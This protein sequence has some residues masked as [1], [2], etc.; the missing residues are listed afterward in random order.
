MQK[1]DWTDAAIADLERHCKAGAS[2]SVIAGLLVSEYGGTLTRNAVIGK[3]SRLGLSNGRPITAKDRQAP[4]RPRPIRRS[5]FAIPQPPRLES[6]R[7][8]PPI[9]PE[10]PP[11]GG[12]P[13]LKLKAHH[14]RWPYG[15]PQEAGFVFCGQPRD[16][17]ATL[18]FCEAHR[19]KARKTT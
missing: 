2:S 10:S 16:P 15:D 18:S 8:E 13:L 5:P 11:D 4:A 17:R 12:V 1:F 9:A 6:V 3:L 14:C 19:L 7:A